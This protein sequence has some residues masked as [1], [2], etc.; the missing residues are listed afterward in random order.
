[1]SGGLPSRAIRRLA[2]AIAALAALAAGPGRA[3]RTAA[4]TATGAGSSTVGAAAAAT[5]SAAPAVGGSA[6]GIAAA[7]TPHA[8]S[9]QASLVSAS[10]AAPARPATSPVLATP[11]APPAPAVADVLTLAA[12]A[13]SFKSVALTPDGARIAWVEALRGADG[14]P[15]ERTAIFAGDVPGP[16]GASPAP[17]R[18]GAGRQ[19]VVEKEPAWSPDGKRLAF[20]S[21]C[22]ARATAAR[23]TGQRA[24]R[25]PGGG[26][27][28]DAAATPAGV[29]GTAAP[30]GDGT[31]AQLQLWVADL[32]SGRAAEVTHLAGQ[33][34]ALAWSPDGGAIAFLHIAG[35]TAEAGPTHPVP[36]DAGVVG[37]KPEAQRLAVVQ[38]ASGTVREVSPPGLYV[39]EFDWSPD[40][41]SFAAVAAR[42]SGDDNWWIAQLYTLD[43]ATGA[44]RS[45]L[46]PD[47]QIAMPRWSPD[48]R[49]IAFIGGLM[50][51]QGVVGGDVYA[52]PATGGEAR[53]LT[54][55]MAA[56]AASLRWSD[57]GQLLAFEIV[58]GA[59]GLARIDPAAGR[60]TRVWT[61][62]AAFE[63]GDNA[64]GLALSRDGRVAAAIASSFDRPPEVW[65]G[66]A[67]GV[68]S[69]TG[70]AAA[71]ATPSAAP[72]VGASASGAAAAAIPSAGPAAVQA[73][74]AAAGPTSSAGPV[75][76]GAGPETLG[77]RQLSHR[78]GD[79]RPAWGEARSL[80]WRSDLQGLVQGWLLAP[81]RSGPGASGASVAAAAGK[82]P[83]VV[84][85]H[86]GPAS[87]HK[88]G[89]PRVAGVL[90]SQGF[91]VLM[92]NPRGSYG[93]GEAFT[94]GNVK[95]FGYGDLRDVL[96]GIDAAAAAAPIDPARSGI[97]GWSYGGY[98]TMWAVTQTRRFRAAVAG[99]GIADWQSYYGQN[100]IDQWMIPYFGASA[101][102]DPWIYAR[103][104]P[105][106]FI[107]SVRTPTLV[108]QGERDAEVPAPQAYEF[109]HA[110]KTLGVETQL[111][112]YPDEGHHLGAASDL[113]RLQRIVDWFR[114]YL[115]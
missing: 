55:G 74:A 94:R 86:G 115:R 24:D 89:W 109:W 23:R 6:T 16:A 7:A 64:P 36:R 26:P 42:G 106:T 27:A 73:G 29:A 4:E 63:T 28:A 60:T 58:D 38:L 84:L 1:M 14:R 52:V 77:W 65:A 25:K 62:P 85:V 9:G 39:Y 100:R 53:D 97:Y 80:H 78:N 112:I 72:A 40:G 8:G 45:L 82:A 71:A 5:P 21:D 83:L 98:L 68:G 66:A 96:G 2:M 104:S 79:L 59:S 46:Q 54:P 10:L 30:A 81:L 20:L 35:R 111:V 19:A 70:G 105:I 75:P 31:A 103:S 13:D 110:L 18:I 41:A 49:E 113:D 43:A 57:G 101:Y 76:V 91:Y 34:K 95:D 15:A 17:R 32:A 108:L 88:P 87:S 93:Q 107:K 56:S 22:S 102:D 51:D 69:S 33:I 37:E 61:L 47:F 114:N 3:A 48:G 99:A 12:A 11:P 92:P 90:A 50:S 67:T 44:A